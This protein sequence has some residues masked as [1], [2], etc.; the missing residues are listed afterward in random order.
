VLR[1]G[2]I[3]PATYIGLGSMLGSLEQG[4]LADILLLEGNPLEDIR[5]TNT[6]RWTVKNGEM[7][8]ANSM[9]QTWPQSVVREPF[10]FEES[11]TMPGQP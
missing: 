2:T 1:A 10:L 7:F 3:L 6:V 4:K 9:D 8:D 5:A 11:S